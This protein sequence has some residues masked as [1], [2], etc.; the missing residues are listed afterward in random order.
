MGVKLGESLKVTT[1]YFAEIKER[2]QDS[3]PDN[4]SDARWLS[5]TRR[6]CFAPRLSTSVCRVT[7]LFS[8]PGFAQPRAEA[9]P[10]YAAARLF[11]ATIPVL[12]SE[13]RRSRQPR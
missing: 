13:F 3:L 5:F 12:R 8:S 9:S 2:L 11:H 6:D 4:D 1:P 10:T 7:I